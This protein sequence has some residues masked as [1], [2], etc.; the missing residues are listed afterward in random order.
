MDLVGHVAQV[1]LVEL[2][3]TLDC[4]HNAVDLV[5]VDTVDALVNHNF[6]MVTENIL[7]DINLEVL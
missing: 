5:H 6:L 2:L 3:G 7:K 4:H 1:E